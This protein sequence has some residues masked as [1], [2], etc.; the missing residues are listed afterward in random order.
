[1]PPTTGCCASSH[2]V[3][4]AWSPRF[5]TGLCHLTRQ[6]QDDNLL[7]LQGSRML[8]QP[9]SSNKGRMRSKH[10]GCCSSFLK[11]RCSVGICYCY[12]LAPCLKFPIQLSSSSHLLPSQV[13]AFP[14]LMVLFFLLASLG[15]CVLL[16]Q[17]GLH[18]FLRLLCPFFFSWTSFSNFSL[19]SFL[20]RSAPCSL[21]N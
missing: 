8:C 5:R 19:S 3:H 11:E 2:M 10:L 18:S 4:Q 13:W 7:V 16:F 21:I 1:M 14:S 9:A 17:P 6:R 15:L 20:C 12:L